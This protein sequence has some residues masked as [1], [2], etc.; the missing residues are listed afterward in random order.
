[1]PGRSVASM[2]GGFSAA[3]TSPDRDAQREVAQADSYPAEGY[4][5]DPP[6]AIDCC[7]ANMAEYV[8]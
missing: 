2:P 4:D 7:E 1:M 8:A 3:S 6:A 5:R